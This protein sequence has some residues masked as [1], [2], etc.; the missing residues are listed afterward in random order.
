MAFETDLENSTFSEFYKSTPEKYLGL[1]GSVLNILTTPSYLCGYWYIRNCSNKEV[2]LIHYLTV[3]ICMCGIAFNIIVTSM[4]IFVT[5]FQP[6]NPILCA[7]GIVWRNIIWSH[8]VCLLGL[9]YV[10]K[11]IYIFIFKNP[12]GTYDVFWC[13]FINGA[14]FQSQLADFVTMEKKFLTYYI[15]SN[16][17]PGIDDKER[18]SYPVMGSMMMSLTAFTLVQLRVNVYKKQ[19]EEIFLG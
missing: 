19:E 3:S 9:I 12:V 18:L 10:V 13:I 8:C 5:Y 11:Y 15:C 4:D 7:W 6:L 2:S 14:I 16:S 1:A 17:L